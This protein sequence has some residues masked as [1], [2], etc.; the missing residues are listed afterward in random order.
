MPEGRR[1]DA[2]DALAAVGR[3]ID[4]E[5]VADARERAVTTVVL[6]G[7]FDVTTSLSVLELARAI[8]RATD[9]LAGFAHGLRQY[10]LADL[11]S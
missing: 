11:S 1:V 7:G 6:R 4:F 3:L 9:R 10:V 2:E 8:E 5:H